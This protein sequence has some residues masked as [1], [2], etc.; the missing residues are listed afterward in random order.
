MSCDC[1]VGVLKTTIF[2]LLWSKVTI[3]SEMLLKIST[4]HRPYMCKCYVTFVGILHSNVTTPMV[5]LQM[6]FQCPQLSCPLATLSMVAA[7]YLQL[8]DLAPKAFVYHVIKDFSLGAAVRAALF[9]LPSEPLVQTG[10]TKVLTTA[11]G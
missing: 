9:A 11:H 8:V 1:L 2:T 6:F 10:L 3:I 5:G 4:L 7:S